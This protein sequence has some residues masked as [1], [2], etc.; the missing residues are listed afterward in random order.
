[1]KYSQINIKTLEDLGMEK[2]ENATVVDKLGDALMDVINS[3]EKGDS[4]SFDILSEIKKAIGS[5]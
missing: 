4:V 1:M 2:L 3:A 5:N